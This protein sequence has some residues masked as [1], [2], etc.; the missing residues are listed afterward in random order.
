MRNI[1]PLDKI[2]IR[3][4]GL[5]IQP[6][7]PENGWKQNVNTF[8][9]VQAVDIQDYVPGYLEDKVKMLSSAKD[10]THKEKRVYPQ[11]EKK[12][13]SFQDV[14]AEKPDSSPLDNGQ[15]TQ[16]FLA[17]QSSL[18]LDQP[19]IKK[20]K[21][22]DYSL[23][24]QYEKLLEKKVKETIWTRDKINL[25]NLLV[26]TQDPTLVQFLKNQT[27]NFQTARREAQKAIFQA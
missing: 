15:L 12:S 22:L 10:T 16:S 8:L 26:K 14:Q 9:K 24:V 17:L 27:H 4:D 1:K 7:N 23:S 18:L 11:A 25:L 3:E 19:V 5:A 20:P 6:A 21:N 13:A 2:G